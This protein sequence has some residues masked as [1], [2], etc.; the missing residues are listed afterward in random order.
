M[1]LLKTGARLQSQQRS[2]FKP[3]NYNLVSGCISFR[4]NEAVVRG[5]TGISASGSF[6]TKHIY[7]YI[8]TEHKSVKPTVKHIFR[9]C[10]GNSVKIYWEAAV[11]RSTDESLRDWHILLLF[12]ASPF[13]R[14]VHH[15]LM[16]L[17]KP[18]ISATWLFEADTETTASAF[19]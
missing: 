19:V 16:K 14:H 6:P 9:E 18:L 13:C 2:L 15:N 11:L 1:R 4:D 5:D 7:I 3:L 17:E 10:S 8:F 12:L